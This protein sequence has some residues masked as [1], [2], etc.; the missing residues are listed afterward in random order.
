[1]F[2]AFSDVQTDSKQEINIFGQGRGLQWIIQ[3]KIL[4]CLEATLSKRNPDSLSIPYF[5]QH[6]LVN[7]KDKS[8]LPR[9]SHHCSSERLILA[10]QAIDKAHLDLML[11]LITA[12]INK[13]KDKYIHTQSV[14]LAQAAEYNSPVI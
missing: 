14:P 4:V 7:W 1:M 5:G 11:H 9:T 6:P 8:G 2:L 3:N 10:Q 13:R 12:S